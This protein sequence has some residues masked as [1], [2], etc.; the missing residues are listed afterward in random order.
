DRTADAFPDSVL[1][2][3]RHLQRAPR[4]PP[5]SD[6]TQT[7]QDRPGRTRRMAA[8]HDRSRRIAGARSRRTHGAARLLRDSVDRDDQ[9]G[10]SGLGDAAAG[11]AAAAGPPAEAILSGR[12]RSRR[13]VGDFSSS[14]ARPLPDGFA[15]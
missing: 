11:R 9:S 3:A 1:G 14:T 12:T 7:V 2:G 5:P 15:L 10:G 4:A 6:A 13:T 8:S